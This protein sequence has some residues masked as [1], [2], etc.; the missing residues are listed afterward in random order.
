VLRGVGGK[1]SGAREW[2]VHLPTMG[3][4]IR[5][6]YQRLDLMSGG[7]RESA[8]TVPSGEC[9]WLGP[10]E[11]PPPPS[12]G[13]SALLHGDGR[14]PRCTMAGPTARQPPRAPACAS[15]RSQLRRRAGL[16]PEPTNG[17]PPWMVL[18]GPIS[19]SCDRQPGPEREAV[20]H[21][22]KPRLIWA[23]SRHKGPLWVHLISEVVDVA[24]PRGFVVSSCAARVSDDGLTGPSS[25]PK[26]G[27]A[28]TE[29]DRVVGPEAAATN[30]GR[31]QVDRARTLGSAGPASRGGRNPIPRVVLISRAARAAPC[32]VAVEASQAASV[33]LAWQSDPIR[34][35]ASE[36]R[37]PTRSC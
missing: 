24:E 8:E 6:S 25:G 26:G 18:E 11:P 10:G 28:R 16:P 4:W 37:D 35:G 21:S 17:R 22:R 15:T 9:W 1:H 33:T 7:L 5:G 29:G 3:R 19:D 36:C 30:R 32:R 2:R 12:V 20:A 14:I 13:L 23:R 27:N 34:V 31:H